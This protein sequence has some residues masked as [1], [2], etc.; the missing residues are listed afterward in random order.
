MIE[1]IVHHDTEFALIIR[2]SY[3]H[4]GIEFF[5]PSDYSQQ[6]A[7]M[8]R[9]SGYVIA[10]HVHNEV[11]RSVSFTKE[12]LFIRSGRVRVDF[13]TEEKKYF[14]STILESGDIILLAFGGHGFEM[15]EPTELIEVK[16]GPYAGE[17]DKTRFDPV[18]TAHLTTRE[19]K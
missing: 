19:T 13:Y 11:L 1:R 7:Y 8:N 16:Q 17:T 12:V 9:P 4:E 3:S 18:D 10:P 14:D 2:R 6:L 15:L 5:T